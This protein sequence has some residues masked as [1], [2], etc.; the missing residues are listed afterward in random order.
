MCLIFKKFA[1]VLELIQTASGQYS[2]VLRQREYS[3]VRSNASTGQSLGSAFL[4]WDMHSPFL[5]FSVFAIWIGRIRFQCRTVAMNMTR[6]SGS[7]HTQ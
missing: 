4:P 6:H 7:F 1:A 3:R 5:N 2:K